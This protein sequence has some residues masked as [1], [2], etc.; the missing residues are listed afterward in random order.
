MPPL[1]IPATIF[2][3]DELPLPGERR[4]L[5]KYDVFELCCALKP[6]A[7]AHIMEKHHVDQLLY[8]DSDILVL[9]PFWEELQLAWAEHSVLLT[10]HVVQPPSRM[11]LEFQRS[12]AQH[13]AYNG[14]CIAIRTNEQ[15]RSFLSCWSDLLARL[16]LLDPMNSL[17]VDQRWLDLLAASSDAVGI[18]RDPGLNVAYWNLHERQLSIDERSNWSVNGRPLKFFH[19]SGFDR[20]RL[21]TKATCADP[22]ALQLAEQYGQALEQARDREFRDRDYGWARYTNGK[23]IAR[24]HRDLIL[25]ECSELAGVVDPFALPEIVGWENLEDLAKSNEPVR[26]SER[27]HEWKH[28]SP[29]LRRLRRHPVI[30]TVWK[31]WERFVNPSLSFNYPANGRF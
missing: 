20:E 5:F 22:L 29:T 13:G 26:I 14:G 28:S 23:V 11:P 17:Y 24:S 21:T 19:F 12:L 8:L 25:S 27:Y 10:P 31:F 18:L 16:C 1:D 4:F 6:F 15:S 2:Y 9:N 7:I 3:A 30:G